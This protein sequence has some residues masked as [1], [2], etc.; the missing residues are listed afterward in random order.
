MSEVF[1]CQWEI[2]F[3]LVEV[4]MAQYGTIRPT[5]Q[6]TYVLLSDAF[7]NI[8]SDADLTDPDIINFLK[9]GIKFV[10][11]M[12]CLQKLYVTSVTILITMLGITI[13]RIAFHE[14]VGQTSN[15]S[16]LT[17]DEE[18]M[19]RTFLADPI[20][21]VHI[22]GVI[23]GKSN[24]DSDFQT[25]FRELIRQADSVLNEKTPSVIEK[26]ELPTSGDITKKGLDECKSLA[27]MGIS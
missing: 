22:K 17:L 19:P 18:R 14:V 27:T 15:N 4:V 12:L 9:L 2:L 6:P 26:N 13:M 23:Q 24:I 7:Y 20:L 21:F 11:V 16:R 5:N 3:L 10:S 1:P 25:S 8:V